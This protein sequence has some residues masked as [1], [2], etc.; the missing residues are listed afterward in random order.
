MAATTRITIA[1]LASAMF[2]G[3]CSDPLTELNS[4]F[5]P[6]TTM[7][8]RQMDGDHVVTITKVDGANVMDDHDGGW[9]VDRF[10]SGGSIPQRYMAAI[11]ASLD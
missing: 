6:G 11:A 1:K 10:T 2:G 7:R 8:I 9:M 5:Y 3:L 4:G